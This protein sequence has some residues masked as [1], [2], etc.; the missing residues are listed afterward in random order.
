MKFLRKVS[1]EKFRK[2]PGIFRSIIFP[3]FS[4][5]NK[6]IGFPLSTRFVMFL[7]SVCIAF[8]NFLLQEIPLREISGNFRKFCFENFQISLPF[9]TIDY[10]DLSN[11][12]VYRLY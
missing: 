10:V 5:K 6:K 7:L 2:F 9:K 1:A 12:Y 3:N 8:E 11:Q 4:G